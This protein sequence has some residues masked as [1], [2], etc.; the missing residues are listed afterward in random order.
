MTQPA[1]PQRLGSLV[2][3]PAQ[4]AG[5]PWPTDAWPTADPPAATAARMSLLL[6]E[7]TGDTARFGTT[8]AVAVVQG[9]TLLAERYG[10]EVEHWDRPDEPVGH[11][12]ELLSWSMAKSILHAAVGVLV[13]EG[14][15][16][17]DMAAPVPEWAEPADPRHA[18]TLDDL[19]TMRDGLDFAEDYDDFERS[20]VIRML[21]GDSQADMAHFAADHPLA[22]EPGTVFNYSSGTSLIV[23][24]IVARTIGAGAR[25]ERFL[26]SR[27]FGPLGMRSTRARFDDAGTFVGSSFVYATAQDYLRFGLLYLRDG[28]WDGRRLLPEGWVDHGRR[29]RSRDEEGD[30]WH[31]AHWWSVGDAV[32]TF[33]ANGYEG[34]SLLIC[35]SLDLMV[36][37]LGKSPDDTHDPELRSWRARVVDAFRTG[38]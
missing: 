28:V 34:Q 35:P 38:L 2:P 17:P 30:R 27:L 4:P 26:R 10:D 32:G 31:G 12:T 8:Y 7:I 6:D 15:L 20:D 29:A 33:T 18:I 11:T 16:T 22:H 13:G 23:S 37:R 1:T 36:V 14:R 25:Y 3:L 9:G 5:V 21:F 24:G 19:L